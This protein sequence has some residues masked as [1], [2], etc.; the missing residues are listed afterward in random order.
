MFVKPALEK[1]ED[2]PSTVDLTNL[3]KSISDFLDD[4]NAFTRKKVLDEASEIALKRGRSN[5][6]PYEIA[7]AIR[8]VEA[9]W[10]GD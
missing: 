2:L 7:V 3:D 5:I 9:R 4:C 6:T 10:V 1:A 8:K